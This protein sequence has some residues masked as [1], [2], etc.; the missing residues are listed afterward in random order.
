MPNNHN[1]LY[2]IRRDLRVDDNPAL[3]SAI[4]RGVSK[5]IFIAPLK[6][7]EQHH[8][9]P[10][11][12]D[13]IARHLQ[14]LKQQLANRGITL[15][16]VEVDDFDAQKQY[17][18]DY[19]LAQNIQHLYA[20]SEPELDEC[21]RDSSIASQ[22]LTL[23]LFEADV[24]MPKGGILNKQG[25]M[26]KVFTPFKRAW[27]QEFR[28]RYFECL[29]P[30]AATKT[31]QLTE[32]ITFSTTQRSSIKWPLADDYLQ[33]V[34]PQFITAKLSHYQQ[35]RDFP[36]VHGTSGISPYLAIGAISPRRVLSNLLSH[37]PQLAEWDSSPLFSW[38]NELIWRE[39]YKHLLFHFPNLSKHQDF[40]PKFK[41]F[42]WPGS[43]EN[44]S[45][46]CQG[47]TGYP[48]VD[49]AMRQL[50]QTGWMHNRLRMIVGSFLTKHLLVDWRKGEAYFMQ[51]LIDGD[52]SANNGGWQWA[53][54]TGCDAQP[55]FRIFNP[56]TQSKRFDAD[57]IFIKKYLPELNDVP[58]KYIHS[59]HEY[60][61]KQ[62]LEK[63][64]WPPIVD[65]A[66]GRARA[67]V[68]FKQQLS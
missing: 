3:T 61:K 9:A 65:L 60:L 15:D 18:T 66:A 59:P 49:A 16:I 48:I 54:G 39:F 26:F 52:F 63:I 64:Y 33:Q 46:W 34:L 53:A 29:P 37:Y 40:Q 5:A 47:K 21:Q 32:S 55:Y 30:P 1:G 2:W 35:Q 42:Y 14:W 24:I 31:T 45:L 41:D 27:L 11:Q 67:L 12:I 23:H 51:Q 58:N 20:N 57:G 44:F 36:G 68:H 13:F 56:V 62:A 7:W 4:E 6:T 28:Q 22:H 38:L 10:I 50:N 25:E 17:L 19:C 43:A 8:K